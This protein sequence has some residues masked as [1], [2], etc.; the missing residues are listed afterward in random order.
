[1]A[2]FCKRKKNRYWLRKRWHILY[3]K[4]RNENLKF[5]LEMTVMAPVYANDKIFY[6]LNY[7]QKIKSASFHSLCFFC[8]LEKKFETAEILDFL[9]YLWV[10]ISRVCRISY[11]GTSCTEPRDDVSSARTKWHELGRALTFAQN[12]FEFLRPG[13]VT[14]G[15]GNWSWNYK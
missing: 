11:I 5:Y 1:M 14:R 3:I 13:S 8:S 15:A 9:T 2:Y 7:L 12:E 6:P 10:L 4:K